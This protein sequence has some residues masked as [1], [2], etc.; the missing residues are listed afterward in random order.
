MSVLQFIL[1]LKDTATGD[2][3]WTGIKSAGSAA[4]AARIGLRPPIPSYVEGY[5]AP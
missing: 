3:P 5:C 2:A 4:V 1:S